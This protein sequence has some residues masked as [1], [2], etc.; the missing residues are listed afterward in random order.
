[1]A[2]G[3]THRVFVA[4]AAKAHDGRHVIEGVEE[5][6]AMDIGHR[7]GHVFDHPMLRADDDGALRDEVGVSGTA[8]IHGDTEEPGHAERL[9]VG[10][11]LFD[12]AE[13]G[14]LALIDTADHLEPWIGSYVMPVCGW[15]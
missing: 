7:V 3:S 1:M 8:V 5:A 2:R 9:R 12:V 13:K 15:A 6:A 4:D 14:L 11:H 10:G